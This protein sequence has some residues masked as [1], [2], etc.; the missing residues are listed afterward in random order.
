MK[1]LATGGAGY[2]GSHT[3]KALACR[4]HEVLVYDSLA[5]GHAHA[6]KW[7]PLV[8]GDIRDKD[9]LESTLATFRPDVVIHFAALAY[10]GESM[11][12]PA[13]YYDV[14]VG[15]TL[16]L[17]DAM[18]ATGTSRIVLSSSCATYGI[19]D[20]LPIR[21]DTPQRPINPY[22]FTKL[23][24]ERMIADFG[25]AH[26][27]AWTALRYFNAAGADPD[28]EIGEEHAPET[29]AIPLAVMAAL[30]TA[31][32]F[33]VMGRD[34]DT[35]DGT[36]IRDYIHVSDLADAHVLAAE[37]LLSGGP[38]IALNLGVGKGVSLLDLLASIERVTG[39]PV[40][41]I[42]A[43]RR[44]GDPPCLYADPSRAKAHLGWSPQFEDLDAIVGSAVAW[45]RRHS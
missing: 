20:V 6:V 35:P 10:V 11:S 29:H 4:G 15:G 28:G 17:L 41:H 36:A 21:E 30:G 37:K 18:R 14:N 33:Q 34:F 16:S 3:C 40:P 26:D 2:I 27:I 9:A 32:P 38:S 8:E 1:V 25:A 22:G 24:C 13:S 7:G 23:V 5:R 19:P 44:P 45:F 39:K 42:D 31:P 12:D 43:P